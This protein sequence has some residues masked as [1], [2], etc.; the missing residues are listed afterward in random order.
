MRKN[1]NDSRNIAASI[2]VCNGA[3]NQTGCGSCSSMENTAFTVQTCFFKLQ[4][5]VKLMGLC[6]SCGVH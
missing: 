4:V 3:G 5:S 2:Q 6:I 1:K